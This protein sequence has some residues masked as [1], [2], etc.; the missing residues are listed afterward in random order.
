LRGVK[1]VYRDRFEEDRPYQ[2]EFNGI[3]KYEPIS[4]THEALVAVLHVGCNDEEGYFYYVMELADDASAKPPA[5]RDQSTASGAAPTRAFRI[6]HSYIPNTLREALRCRGRLPPIEAAQVTL[7][8]AAALAHLHAHGLVHRD[9]KPSN[10]IFVG[11]KP[12]LADIGLVTGAG[13]S[14]SF[15]GTEGFIPPE[16]PGT[17]EADLYSLGKL[18]YEVATGR[19]RLEFPQLP[20]N[21]RNARESEAVLDLNEIITRACAPR[22]QERYASATEMIADLNLFLSGRSLRGAR[23]LEQNLT[24]LKRF[25][26]A[27]CFVLVIAGG[28]LWLAHD[29]A[30]QARR[31]ERESWQ[32]AQFES[33]LRQRAEA[34]ESDSRRQ[35]HAA[36]QQE[37]Y[38]LVR[39][40]EL[41]Q[42]VRALDAIREA[43]D[44]SNAAS[45]RSIALSALALPDLRFERELAVDPI[46]TAWSFDPAFQ[47]LA[48]C[49]GNE[50]IE[51]DSAI[52]GRPLVALPPSVDLSA[53]SVYWSSDGHY[54]A[55]RRDHRENVGRADMELWEMAGPRQVM[56]F[57]NVRWGAAS[58]HPHLAQFVV[59]SPKGSLTCWDLPARKELSR[60]DLAGEPDLLALAPQG[61]RF[62]V[63]CNTQSGW[64][65]SI[66]KLSNGT[67]LAHLV[68][69]E[70]AS[71]I[72]WHP[73][74]RWLGV[75]DFGGSVYLIDSVTAQAHFLGRHKAQAVWAKFSPDGGYL[76]TGGWE[77]ALICWDVRTVERAFG[78][79]VGS[80][81]GQFIGD[82]RAYAIATGT[83][84]RIH[85]F[86]L[87]LSRDFQDDLGGRVRR[88]VFSPDGRWLAASG[89][90]RLG[91]WDLSAQTPNPLLTNIAN[92]DGIFFSPDSSQLFATCEGGT[93]R[94]RIVPATE[95]RSPPLLEPLGVPQPEGFSSICLSSN[96]IIFT[97]ARG[98][99][100]APLAD[101]CAEVGPWKGTVA[102]INGIS[103]DGRWLAIFKPFTPWL[104][105]YHLPDCKP[106][107]VLT[108]RNNIARFEFLPTG[109]Q[110]AISSAH[111]VEL[112]NTA[113]WER[114][115]ELTNYINLMFSGNPNAYWLHKDYQRAGLYDSRS[116]DPLLPLPNGTLPLA[117]S[118]DGRYL[119]VSVDAQLVRLWDLTKVREEFK[120]IGINWGNSN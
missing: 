20:S 53:S 80:F 3:L 62:A 54:L 30:L 28:A 9:V 57:T 16:G 82:G 74:G 68:L 120:K 86:E 103:P 42:R 91:L 63:V 95:P 44:R 15:V 73:E 117:V 100:I 46:V 89:K 102:G 39:S 76:L 106:V 66:H 13:D 18:L 96:A 119:A 43:A 37:A 29:A 112:W 23:K 33:A 59:A 116:L 5:S 81:E 19:D 99:K 94:W 32:T 87:P 71:S 11:A 79:D 22:S 51:I 109:D 118:R 110:I 24:W 17:A 104:Q 52:D 101:P 14:R 27:V 111:R 31:R 114:S 35:L 1:V 40:R 6:P 61:D 115:R 108:N 85:S 107:T 113:T 58:F 2:R 75:V 36:L 38:G 55:V 4:R 92:A 56:L 83:A 34:A 105:I 98:S 78:I 90:D 84:I 12:K 7:E 88:A 8:V 77:R 10:V 26:M 97:D 65:L 47:R 72:D 21:L 49:H 50:A 70:A 93:F 64:T 41:G 69:K 45:L 25:S 48:V 60:F 67:P